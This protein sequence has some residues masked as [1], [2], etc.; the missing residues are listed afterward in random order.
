MAVGGTAGEERGLTK[1][2]A[3]AVTT[4]GPQPRAV[5][6][7]SRLHLWLLRHCGAAGFLGRDVLVLTTTGRR[8]G[9]PRSTP[10]YYVH[11]GDAADR[12]YW[13]AASFAGRNAPPAWYL[14]LIADPQ[15]GVQ[16]GGR[17]IA[18]HARV[19]EPGEAQGVWPRLD[20]T[21]R[22][23]ARYR[24]RAERVI[25]VI[26][27]SRRVLLGAAGPPPLNHQDSARR[28]PR[29]A[30]QPQRGATPPHPGLTRPGVARPDLV[31]SSSWRR[32]WGMPDPGGWCWFRIACSMR[33]PATS[34]AP[35]VRD[36]SPRLW[37][38]A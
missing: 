5:R 31:R 38:P 19:L 26:E 4:G 9:V 1:R 28:S 7:G 33:T 36:A 27:L 15:V 24:R 34:V 2:V 10:L 16:V 29:S 35:A 11:R 32:G 17:R 12:K 18:C 3:S 23:F 8:T 25:P 6:L 14:N 22:P 30:A 37:K 20:A 13:V 21:Y